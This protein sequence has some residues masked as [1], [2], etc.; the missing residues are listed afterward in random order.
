MVWFTDRS[1]RVAQFTGFLSRVSN[2]CSASMAGSLMSNG[3]SPS[4]HFSGCRWGACLRH[5]SKREIVSN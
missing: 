2:R 4:S 3:D 1:G 5:G